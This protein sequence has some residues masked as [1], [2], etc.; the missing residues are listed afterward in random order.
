VTRPLPM[1]QM[2]PA[3]LWH[4]SAD[5]EA[6]GGA[7]KKRGRPPKPP[8]AILGKSTLRVREW[9]AAN[10][11]RHPEKPARVVPARAGALQN[12]QPRRRGRPPFAD[13]QISKRGMRGREDRARAAEKKRQA[14][15]K[16]LLQVAA[17]ERLRARLAKE[18]TSTGD[19]GPSGFAPTSV[20][21][22]DGSHCFICLEEDDVD[23]RMACCKHLVHHACVLRWN[24]M[25]KSA[26]VPAPVMADNDRDEHYSKRI[27]TCNQCAMCRKP[28]TRV[29]MLPKSN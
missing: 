16:L 18:L 8:G 6:S 4:T 21:A 25:A 22:P 11:P 20:E 10:P 1:L 5:A 12:V 2:G 3:L 19:D 24:A 7:R 17:Q 23:C 29:W 27:E 26:Y 28:C 14:A 9:R 13:D 15:A